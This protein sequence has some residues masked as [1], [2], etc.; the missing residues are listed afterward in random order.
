MDERFRNKGNAL[1]RFIEECGE[2][3]AAAGKTVRYGW[4]SYNPLPGA[5]KEHNETWLRREIRD[6]EDAI[7]RLK[8]ERGWKEPGEKK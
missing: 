5:S 4:D 2:T 6:L 3:L 1:G 8:N 7:A